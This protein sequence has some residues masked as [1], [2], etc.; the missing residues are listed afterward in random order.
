[1]RYYMHLCGTARGKDALEIKHLKFERWDSYVQCSTVKTHGI[2]SPVAYHSDY[3]KP[4]SDPPPKCYMWELRVRAGREM[5][6]V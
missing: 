2:T 1:M 3:M 4:E 5:V 6:N